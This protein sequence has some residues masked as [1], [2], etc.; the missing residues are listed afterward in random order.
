MK[1]VIDIDE[2]VYKSFM[3]DYVR[4]PDIIYAVRKGTP[5]PKEHGRLIDAKELSYNAETCIETTD[6]F[7]DLINEAPT[8][9]EAEVEKNEGSD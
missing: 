7:I 5:L 2:E 6:A 8:I 4:C 1:I 9:I 3:D